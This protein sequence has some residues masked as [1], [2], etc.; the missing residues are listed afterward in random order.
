MKRLFTELKW[1]RLEP[2]DELITAGVDRGED[3]THQ[4]VIAPPKTT[5][6][7][8]AEIGGQYVAYVRGHEGPVELSLGEAPPRS[9][10]LRQLDP[11]SGEFRDLG[12]HPGKGPVRYTPPDR[13]DWVLVVTALE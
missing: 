3:S 2:H 5:Y 11:R 9:C 7:A 1:R 8:L 13:Q 4:G 6:W 12:T 10:R